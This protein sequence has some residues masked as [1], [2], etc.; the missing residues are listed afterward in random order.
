MRRKAKRNK[1][2]L[3]SR[4]LGD[5][6]QAES[7]AAIKRAVAMIVACN[8][9]DKKNVTFGG[10]HQTL[11]TLSALH[12]RCAFILKS[13]ICK[14]QLSIDADDEDGDAGGGG[15]GVGTSSATATFT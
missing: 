8:F 9:K 13:L 6:L 2:T 15:G 5:C 1:D 3:N 11:F 4:I 14:K 12:E 7:P 10:V